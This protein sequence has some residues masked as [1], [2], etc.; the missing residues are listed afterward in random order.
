MKSLGLLRVLMLILVFG[1]AAPGYAVNFQ[2]LSS[3]D[4]SIGEARR[5]LNYGPW[6]FQLYGVNL[7][8][9]VEEV[10]T[11]L[12]F[13]NFPGLSRD[14]IK[15][16]VEDVFP[17]AALQLSQAEAAR[18]IPKVIRALL[19]RQR[20]NFDTVWNAVVFVIRNIPT[21]ELNFRAITS[22]FQYFELPA[23]ISQG[24]SD[25]RVQGQLVPE[26]T[27]NFLLLFRNYFPRE[28]I[29]SASNVD[30]ALGI[31]DLN[32][33]GELDSFRNPHRSAF[34]IG[35]SIL[36]IIAFA[37]SL[38]WAVLSDENAAWAVCT[39]VNVFC[40][41][42]AVLLPHHIYLYL[43]VK[44]KFLDDP[45]NRKFMEYLSW[46]SWLKSSQIRGPNQRG[47]NP[48]TGLADSNAAAYELVTVT[49]GN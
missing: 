29:P 19:P 42:I 11:R 49:S 3:E 45:S 39:I 15:A 8:Y 4:V 18:I 27:T 33:E 2:M 32:L 17:G 13:Q 10:M 5:L 30:A 6:N 46:L 21:R 48:L 37:S 34:L 7:I 31:F 20:L 28:V 43:N 12:G 41:P 47:S 24:T 23:I 44:E 16:Q 35:T 14:T 9:A 36:A 25:A 38:S 1:L 22:I 40:L 26:D